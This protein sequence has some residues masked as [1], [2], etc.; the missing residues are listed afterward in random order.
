MFY[1]FNLGMSILQ[2]LIRDPNWMAYLNV[3][4]NDPNLKTIDYSRFRILTNHMPNLALAIL[5]KF[6]TSEKTSI[7]YDFRFIDPTPKSVGFNLDNHPM[8]ILSKT[9]NSRILSHR[10]VKK[11]AGLKWTGGSEGLRNSMPVIIF[12]FHF[13]LFLTYLIFITLLICSVHNFMSSLK[14]ADNAPAPLISLNTTQII[15]T[16]YSDYFKGSFN[17]SEAG[18]ASQYNS[19]IRVGKL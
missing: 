5:D 13:V 8:F 19:T 10:V 14:N 6:A 1:F 3:D 2:A 9:E 16:N 11:L 12:I 15:P 17:Y 18:N 4:L 7:V